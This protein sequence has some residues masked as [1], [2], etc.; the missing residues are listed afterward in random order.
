[1]IPTTDR[2][3]EIVAMHYAVAVEALTPQTSFTQQLDGDDLD[4]L[5]LVCEVEETFEVVFNDDDMEE[6]GTVGDLIRI[7]EG[8]LK[9][10]AGAAA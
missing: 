1:M 4:R 8:K 2:L 3:K 9:A 7:V 10:K 6:L 5:G